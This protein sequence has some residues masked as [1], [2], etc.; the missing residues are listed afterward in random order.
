MATVTSNPAQMLGLADSI[1]SL[2][3][4]R[5]ADISVLDVLRGRFELRDNSGE[6]VQ[7]A[8]MIVPSFAV[9][10]GQRCALDS[11]LVPA[12]VALAA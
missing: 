6:R 12:P 9:R 10:A 1:G 8:E 2:Q 3:V 4:G 5:E 7:A 11:P